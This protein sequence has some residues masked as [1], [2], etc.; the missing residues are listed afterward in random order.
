MLKF[1]ERWVDYE[2]FSGDRPHP[3]LAFD[4]LGVGLRYAKHCT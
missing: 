1:R 4:Y 2:G 3:P